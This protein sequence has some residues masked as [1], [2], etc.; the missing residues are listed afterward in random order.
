M[1][2]ELMTFNG[3]D[4]A[5]GEYLL[6][7][8]S[9]LQV[10]ALAQGHSLPEAEVAQLK[11]RLHQLSPDAGVEADARD[12]SQTGWGVIFPAHTD[13]AIKDAL[14]PLLML[15][16]EQAGDLYKEF[17]GSQGYVPGE[18]K[19][20][21]LARHQVGPGPAIPSKVPYY[22]L[23][24]G[25]PQTIP[26]RVQYLLD[27]QYAVGRIHF[28]QLED[29]ARY[30]QSVVEAEKGLSLRPQATFFGVANPDDRATE[31][32]AREL[33]LPLAQKIQQEQEQWAAS[34]LKNRASAGLGPAPRWEIQMS[35][36]GEALKKRLSDLLNGPQAP[37]L[38]FTAS[39]GIAF[40]NG[41]E[42]QLPHQGAL[43][44]GDWPGPLEHHGPV[45][46]DYYFS[47]EDLTSDANLLGTLAFFFACFGAGT[48]K[49][50]EFAH[51]I[52]KDKPERKSIAPHDFI[53][54]LPRRM[55]SLPRG[56]AL[57]VVGHI[58]RAWGTSFTWGSA[59]PQ[60]QVFEDC[61][62][63]LLSGGHPI[64][65]ALE[66]FNN[67]FA[68]LSVELNNEIE[69]V[70]DFGKKANDV[71][72][73]NLWTANN[74]ARNYVIL[75]DPA[76][77]LAVSEGFPGGT[78]RPVIDEITSLTKATKPVSGEPDLAPAASGEL[79]APATEYSLGSLAIE[80]D[81]GVNAQFQELAGWLAAFL[82][83]ALEESSNV[84][85]ATYVSNDL[86]GVRF[87]PASGRLT[88]AELRALA[89]LQFSGET[90][91]CLPE[92]P[93]ALDPILWQM[94]MDLLRE[95]QVARR[96]LL[97]AAI[98]AAGGLPDGSRD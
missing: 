57:A 25:D 48:P 80:A 45:P 14:Q 92:P 51:R 54:G 84:E 24:V 28:S 23:I 41:H 36:A 29:Y 70:R 20:D 77:R 67:R 98:L 73:S 38:L 56:G 4:G 88:G 72:L 19:D 22:L 62:K 35:L 5:S 69:K 27:V 43:V 86:A 53:A 16:K 47:A 13:P 49:E 85:V 65:Y 31:S 44:C 63:R 26:Y 10:S 78:S 3:L 97:K 46:P 79:L 75:G 66:V 12:L 74:D 61:F 94:H 37:A 52:W 18:T 59:G 8:M 91:S 55:L 82:R 1:A 6:P 68:E 83:Q 39:H 89:R 60:L 87:D 15:R 76:A 34:L 33:V 50:D 17:S 2:T 81:L 96:E 71:K 30:A 58:E 90:L 9:P 11:Q 32:S 93:E 21:F 42:R 64:G 95:V 7:P 40:P